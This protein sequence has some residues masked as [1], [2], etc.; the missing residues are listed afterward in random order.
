MYI[1]G[2]ISKGKIII[3]FHQI[4]QLKYGLKKKI[5][6]VILENSFLG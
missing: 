3:R 4:I 5:D 2:M 6:D 1:F